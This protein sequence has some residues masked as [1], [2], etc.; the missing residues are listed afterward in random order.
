MT[1][2]NERWCADRELQIAPR[3]AQS[4]VSPCVACVGSLRVH[5]VL[6]GPGRPDQPGPVDFPGSSASTLPPRQRPCGPPPRALARLEALGPPAPACRGKAGRSFAR[7]GGLILYP[8]G[9][10]AE[11]SLLSLRGPG[12]GGSLGRDYDHDG[13]DARGGGERARWSSPG[14][15][16][17]SASWGGPSGPGSRSW[18]VY[19]ANPSPI[20]IFFAPPP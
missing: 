20:N 6:Q 5:G 8:E 3:P 13:G 12:G 16:C 17:G 2:P 4:E 1:S 15:G 9:R 10:R 14:C 11:M 18:A 19:R 7:I